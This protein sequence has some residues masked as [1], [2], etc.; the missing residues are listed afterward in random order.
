MRIDT[1]LW[2][3][4]CFKIQPIRASMGIAPNDPGAQTAF[5]QT[6]LN[7]VEELSPDKGFGILDNV[8]DDAEVNGI[9]PVVDMRIY[10]DQEDGP[11][12]FFTASNAT[13]GECEP[14]D[15]DCKDEKPEF[16]GQY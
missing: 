5:D 10:W 2:E 6:I 9:Y 1:R 16:E 7:N 12:Y 3:E 13:D 15:E 14:E 8:Q 4:G 11:Q